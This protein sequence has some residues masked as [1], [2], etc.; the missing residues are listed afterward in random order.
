MM[1]DSLSDAHHCDSIMSSSVS[2]IGT[3]ISLDFVTPRQLAVLNLRGVRYEVDIHK[4]MCQPTTLLGEITRR[5]HKLDNKGRKF[6]FYFNRDPY[7]FNSILNFYETGHLHFREGVCVDEVCS[8]LQFW[9]IDLTE[10]EDCCWSRVEE[11]KLALM[12]LQQ[13]APPCNG[14]VT[15]AKGIRAQ[16][17]I[18]LNNPFSSRKALVSYFI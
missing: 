8:E 7:I 15:C 17:H 4:L 11:S 12:R 1:E 9:H 2:D 16:I 18:F 14:E 10:L 6:E 3:D 5:A 13:V